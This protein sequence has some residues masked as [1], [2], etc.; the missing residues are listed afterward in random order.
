M[1][2]LKICLLFLFLFLNLKIKL[3]L[4]F[5]K[6]LLLLNLLIK[7]LLL[8][9]NL[10]LNLRWESF[11]LDRLLFWFTSNRLISGGNWAYLFLNTLLSNFA[12]LIFSI[13]IE[14]YLVIILLTSYFFL[15]FKITSRSWTALG[16]TSGAIK[17]Q[18]SCTI[19][20]NKR[21]MFIIAPT[22]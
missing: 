1:F 13:W 3:F 18:N 21:I 15:S 8:K 9:R 6:L 2:C 22:K 14:W 20:F 5:E 12:S 7:K 11:M 10:M 4:L 17:E 19:C 16:T